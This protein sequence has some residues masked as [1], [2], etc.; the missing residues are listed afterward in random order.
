MKKRETLIDS[1]IAEDELALLP[2]EHGITTDGARFRHYNGIDFVPP[3]EKLIWSLILAGMQPEDI[4]GELH[5]MMYN[6]LPMEYYR[7]TIA[8]MKNDEFYGKYVVHNQNAYENRTRVPAIPQNNP[9]IFVGHHY[10]EIICQVHRIPVSR[11]K[12]IGS[13][14]NRRIKMLLLLKEARQFIECA[15]LCPFGLDEIHKL[16]RDLYLKQNDDRR[17]GVMSRQVIATYYHYYWQY[18]F[19]KLMRGHVSEIDRSRYIEAAVGITGIVNS[20]YRPHIRLNGSPQEH[21]YTWFGMAN[22][23]NR[24]RLNLKMLG[25][26]KIELLNRLEEDAGILNQVDVDLL[27]YLDNVMAEDEKFAKSEEKARFIDEMDEVR[28]NL[29]VQVQKPTEELINPHYD[30]ATQG[31]KDTDVDEPFRK[32]NASD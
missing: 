4:E 12:I 30:P 13:M 21:F 19:S 26:I 20:Y 10:K 7:N 18:N 32:S 6:E 9:R 11:G 31:P 16:W 1:L 24:K 22:A 15:S 23:D 28:K 25:K 8:I 27:K 14:F 17:Y 5:Q 29:C 3:H 2:A